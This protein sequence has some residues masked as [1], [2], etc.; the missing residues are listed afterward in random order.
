VHKSN[1][2]DFQ[3]GKFV[4]KQYGNHFAALIRVFPELN[5][6]PE[7]FSQYKGGLFN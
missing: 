7:K 4:I 5:L 1:L 6:K 2:F 3:D